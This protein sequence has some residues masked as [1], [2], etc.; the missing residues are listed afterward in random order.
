ILSGRKR[1]PI[2]RA[3]ARMARVGTRRDRATAL[4][5]RLGMS[6]LYCARPLYGRL[7]CRPTAYLALGSPFLTEPRRLP[8]LHFA[9]V[10]VSA[11]CR[12]EGSV[13]RVRERDHIADV[14]VQRVE[15]L[16][17]LQIPDLGGVVA[18]P[19]GELFGVGMEGDADDAVLVVELVQQFGGLD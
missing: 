12:Q 17:G 3:R 16:A 14:A 7:G 6:A 5:G 9:R 1:S 15:F 4:M 8:E 10:P 2:W 11:A 13:R 18:A 19:G